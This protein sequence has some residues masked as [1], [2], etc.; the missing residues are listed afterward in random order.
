MVPLVAMMA[1][2]GVLLS[3][4]SFSFFAKRSSNQASS[5][6]PCF[7]NRSWGRRLD[8]I[9]ATVDMLAS[10]QRLAVS[11]TEGYPSVFADLENVFAAVLLGGNQFVTGR[12][13]EGVE[14]LDRTRIGGADTQNLAMLQ[15]VD[16][17]LR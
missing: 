4:T 15:S 10:F 17:L 9:S 16:G 8:D 5:A 13:A 11:P 1:S 7:C 3:S 6:E 12:P 2:D 14:I